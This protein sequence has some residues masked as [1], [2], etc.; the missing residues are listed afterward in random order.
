VSPKPAP[1]SKSP[2]RFAGAAYDQFAAGLHRF[3]VQRLRCAETAQDIAQEAYLR[4]L[5][6]E[7]TDLV[8]KPQAYL[9]RIARNLI[10]E[11]KLRDGRDP[12][13]FDSEILER[14]AET[15]LQLP[16]DEVSARLCG[17]EEL[18]AVLCQL[19][20]LYRAVLILRKRDGLSYSEIGKALDLSPHTVKKYLARALAQCRTARWDKSL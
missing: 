17:A 8:L 20:A 9:Y 4:L 5:R 2:H 6:V 13:T 15:P 16:A 11:Y 3:L 18:E 7:N 10:Y 1:S 12:V 19:P 14:L